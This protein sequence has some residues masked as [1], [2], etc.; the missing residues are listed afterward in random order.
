MSRI[1]IQ[2][3]GSSGTLAYMSPQ[4]AQGGASSPLDDVYSLGAT[5]YELLTSKPPFYSG[6][7]YQQVL[8]KLPVP[9]SER[10]AELGVAGLPIPAAWEETIMACLAKD[11]ALRP[12][13][14]AEVWDRL[15]RVEARKPTILKQASPSAIANRKS[16][17][18]A[19][20]IAGLLVILV[21]GSVAGW[22]YGVRA[23]AEK[24][25]LEAG[26]PA[27]L[28]YSTE[29]QRKQ[30]AVEL[31]HTE[32]EKPD[33]EVTRQGKE[34]KNAE[35]AKQANRP[36]TLMV[37]DQFATVQTA[38]DAARPGD[39]VMVKAGVYKEAITFKDGI[40]LLGVEVG[41]CRIEAAD[42]A[43]AILTAIDCKSG[44]IENLTFSGNGKS[45][46]LIFSLGWTLEN[47][48]GG[49]YVKEVNSIGPAARAGIVPGARI[50]L[51]NGREPGK[52]P[53]VV[54]YQ[55]A[56]G[57]QPSE[58][59]IVTE[60]NGTRQKQM[61]QT[62]RFTI[63]GSWPDG[64]VLVDSSITITGCVVAGVGGTGIAV[65]GS[66][67]NATIRRNQCRAN[68]NGIGLECGS[69]SEVEGNT[70]ESNKL[71]GISVGG[72][73]TTAELKNNTCRKNEQ[74]GIVFL[75]SSS[76]LA[77]GNL[78]E[79][80][81]FAG[82]A[83]IGQGTR[84]ELKN[85]TCRKSEQNGMIFSGASSG[86]AE[87]NRCEENRWDGILVRDQGTKAELKNNTCRN[88]EQHGI[89][90]FRASSGTAEGNCCEENKFSGIVAGGQG[91]KTELKNNAC[92]NNEQNGIAFIDAS[93]GTAE[94]N[95]CDEN[96]G[97]GILVA[98][99]GTTAELEN[100]ICRKNGLHGIDFH[101]SSTGTA[102]RNR[103]EEN[104]WSGIAVYRRGTSPSIIGNHCNNNLY[105]GIVVAKESILKAFE[106]NTTSGNARGQIA[107]S[108]IFN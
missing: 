82:I 3:A 104:K 17:M 21:L 102:Q 96:K 106:G 37:P 59:E 79:E 4:Q 56:L 98:G 46:N 13:C 81:K 75:A 26:T 89:D 103:C 63:P 44:A 101:D 93:S 30:A 92:R 5:L 69:K 1:T 10:R 41:A 85:N 66:M 95:R 107:R 73:G 45:Q 76:G 70:C 40:R 49:T 12:Q 15:N 29:N 38:I 28:E 24:A 48:E 42:G 105:Y 62:D 32:K 22:Y 18:P 72:Q 2:P 53:D 6:E 99:H 67:A 83:V 23:A 84:A 11:P 43:A 25:R 87:A 27:A 86:T 34:A 55:L 51:I 9:I 78:C 71:F 68:V 80:N 97:I 31:L 35:A 94:A 77:E 90:F 58:V 36:K 100:N 33:A 65:Q 57:G 88:N 64:M 60:A 39:T 19:A 14:T 47:R 7:I 8:N 108:A 91:T 50:V 52:N 54:S 20:L 16:I 74:N 61:L